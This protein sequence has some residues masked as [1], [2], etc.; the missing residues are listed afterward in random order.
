[1]ISDRRTKAQISPELDHINLTRLGALLL[2]CADLSFGHF[3]SLRWQ[4]DKQEWHV[5]A[6]IPKHSRSC[7]CRHCP[8]EKQM[9]GRSNV[10]PLHAF[11]DACEGLRVRRA[12]RP[13]PLEHKE[14]H[15]A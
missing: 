2:A 15:H 11:D 9:I 14:S 7:G 3:V 8:G 4:G 12:P 1:M 5:S 10:S 13:L 6:R